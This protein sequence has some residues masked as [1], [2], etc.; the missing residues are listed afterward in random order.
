MNEEDF[1]DAPASSERPMRRKDRE[2]SLTDAL[3][4]VRAAHYAVLSTTDAAGVP[5]GA[6]VSP[7]LTEDGAHLYFHTTREKSRK[8]DNMLDNPQV[9]LCFVAHEATVAAEYSVDYASA[10]VAGRAALV[11]DEAERRRAAALICARYVGEDRKAQSE[12]YFEQAGRAV[13][14]WRVDV[15]RVSGKSRGWATISPALG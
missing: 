2:L 3:R 1:L 11:L 14:I 10:V 15:E 7:V 6:P 5:Y 12:A 9:S 13:T 8:A 4:I